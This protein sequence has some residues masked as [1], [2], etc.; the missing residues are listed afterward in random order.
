MATHLVKKNI[1]LNDSIMDHSLVLSPNIGECKKRV[2]ISARNAQNIRKSLASYERNDNN[3]SKETSGRNLSQ[4]NEEFTITLNSLHE[5]NSKSFNPSKAFN[6]NVLNDVLSWF[7]KIENFDYKVMAITLDAGTKVYTSKVDF[8]YEHFHKILSSLSIATIERVIDDDDNENNEGCDAQSKDQKKKKKKSSNL[9]AVN[10]ET[11]NAKL[12]KNIEIDPLFQHLS[13]AFDVGNVNSLL[14]ANLNINQNG[15]LLLDSDASLNFDCTPNCFENHQST[16]PFLKIE[17]AF[18][19]EYICKPYSNF[20]FLRR[21]IEITVEEFTALPSTQNSLVDVGFELDAVIEEINGP[22]DDDDN[23]DFDNFHSS[24]DFDTDTNTQKT[25]FDPDKTICVSEAYDYEKF[26]KILPDENDTAKFFN[27]D[28]LRKAFKNFRY[29]STQLADKISTKSKANQR[30]T[31]AV[32]LENQYDF[33]VPQEAFKISDNVIFLRPT[34]N[35][36]TTNMADR[37][38]EDIL[39]DCRKLP[40]QNSFSRDSHFI[41]TLSSRYKTDRDKNRNRFDDRIENGNDDHFFEDEHVRYD[42]DGE[43]ETIGERAINSDGLFRI[44][45][46]TS[47]LFNNE[48]DDEPIHIDALDIDYA[49]VA[50]KIDIK[51]VKNCMWNIIQKQETNSDGNSMEGIEENQFNSQSNQSDNF[52]FLDLRKNLPNLLNNNLNENLS[53]PISFVALLHLS[54]DDDDVLA[55]AI[56]RRRVIAL[57]VMFFY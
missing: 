25:N 33:D 13:A 30:R 18:S 28:F 12:E 15:L 23:F 2:S 50:K 38:I 14:L 20:D 16:L 32:Y 22:D 43:I 26:L 35:K 53:T 54:D 49:K 21:D 24:D 51:K 52:S 36:W 9:I 31:R 3:R 8:I 55:I 4:R 34:V 19:N 10:V 39:I 7:N 37:K 47:S 11:L 29:K 48:N 17:H 1:N 5:I 40:F 46:Q 27:R 44:E 6:Y 42:S 56:V 41:E 57:A 45:A